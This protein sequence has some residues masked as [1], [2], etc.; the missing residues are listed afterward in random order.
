MRWGVNISLL[1]AV[2]LIIGVSIGLVELGEQLG[3]DADASPSDLWPS[4]YA[5]VVTAAGAAAAA[6]NGA[7]FFR[8]RR[9]AP[10][11]RAIHLSN[12]V[13]VLLYL[14]GLLV[15]LVMLYAAMPPEL[16]PLIHLTALAALVPFAGIT[17]IYAVLL[18]RQRALRMT[19]VVSG[20]P[21]S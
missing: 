18:R 3:P 16:A 2:S 13:F 19:S 5:T 12:G 20:S 15:Y 21:A 17:A 6:C 9:G 1:M 11:S 4:V 7:G 8:Q 10:M 14:P